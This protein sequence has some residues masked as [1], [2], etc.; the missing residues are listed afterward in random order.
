MN[1]AAATGSFGSSTQNV[2]FAIPINKALRIADQI[3]RGKSSPSVQIGSTGFLGG[4]GP[5][6][7][8]S[9]AQSP[10][11]QRGPQLKQEQGSA[12]LPR[13]PSAPGWLQNSPTARGPRP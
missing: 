11:Q 12:G 10:Q 3:I 1:P 9:Q 2:G 8:A 13:A 6:G 4:L 7:P 5:A